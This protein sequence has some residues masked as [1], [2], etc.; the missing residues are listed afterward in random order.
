[1]SLAASEL[2]PARV[3][4]PWRRFIESRYLLGVG[5][6]LA[7]ILTGVGVILASSPPSEGP[8]GPASQMMLVILGFNLI[9]IAALAGLL[10]DL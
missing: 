3:R 8:I 1:M 5:Y 6:A 7:A 2:A 10:P 9:L 4:P